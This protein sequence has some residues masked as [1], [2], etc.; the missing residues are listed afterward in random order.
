M[1][2]SVRLLLPALLALALGCGDSTDPPLQFSSAELPAAVA[3]QPYQV[4][5]AV[6]NAITP[7]AA[8]EVV[9]GELPPGLALEVLLPLDRK[10]WR[11]AGTPTAAGTAAFTVRATCFGTNHPGQRGEQ[12]YTL[13]VAP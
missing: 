6:T 7:L 11:L 1:T 9:A 2:S 10:E 4:V 5:I 12:A 3:G 8:V 13:L